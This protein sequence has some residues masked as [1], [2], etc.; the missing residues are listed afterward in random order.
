MS[1]LII[2]DYLAVGVY[3]HVAVC[4]YA[5]NQYPNEAITLL[6]FADPST[7]AASPI[8]PVHVHLLHY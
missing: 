3:P 7:I 6:P 5:A 2:S 8:V 1:V 4:G